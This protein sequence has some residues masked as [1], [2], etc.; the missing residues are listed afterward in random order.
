MY[1]RRRKDTL[2][3]RTAATSPS[4][5][6]PPTFLEPLTRARVNRPISTA[7]ACAVLIPTKVHSVVCLCLIFSWLCT[8]V[9]CVRP[10]RSSVQISFC[11]F[12]FKFCGG[13]CATATFKFH[14]T[15]CGARFQMQLSA[16]LTTRHNTEQAADLKTTSKALT[17]KR[18]LQTP[19]TRCECWGF[20]S[21]Q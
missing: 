20:P 18:C 9:C 17:R 4:Y 3:A 19:P 10:A 2:S 12:I 11:S 5:P 1:W 6:T 7:P 8:R 21:L 15:H 14:M 13:H 16:C